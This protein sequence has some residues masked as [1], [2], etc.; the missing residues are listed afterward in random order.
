MNNID[1]IKIEK[2]HSKLIETAKKHMKSITDF[3]HNIN[4]MNDV[5][6]YT[7]ELLNS[8][9]LEVNADICLISAYWHDVGRIKVD[10]GHEKLSAE[11]LKDEMKKLEYDDELINKCYKAIENHKWNMNPKTAEGMVLKDA[12]KLAWLGVGRW[13][14]C[15]NNNQNLDSIMNLLPKLRDEILYFNESKKIYDRD[16][17]ELIKLLYNYKSSGNKH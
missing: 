5:V 2:N 1:F 13:I 16:I 11:I 10:E 7:K 8:I 15:L 12:D 3:E 14:D 6:L 17:I 9:K 4:H